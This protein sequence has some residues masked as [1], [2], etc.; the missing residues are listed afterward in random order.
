MATL[1]YTITGSIIVL[2]ILS[3]LTVSWIFKKEHSSLY[4]N[5]ILI[6]KHR[7]VVE[8][9]RTYINLNTW[10]RRNIICP[11]IIKIGGHKTETRC[12]YPPGH[13]EQLSRSLINT[14]IDVKRDGDLLIIRSTPFYK[15]GTRGSYAGILKENFLFNATEIEK[16]PEKYNITWPPKDTRNYRLVWRVWDLEDINLP[17]GNYTNCSYTFG[18]VKI[19]L[20]NECKKL[21]RAEI[22]DDKIY[23]YF[24]PRKNIQFLEIKIVDPPTAPYGYHIAPSNGT[25][26][27]N[28]S[29]KFEVNETAGTGGDLSNITLHIW[30][31]SSSLIYTNT[32]NISGEYNQTNWT[33]TLPS[34]GTYIWSALI[35]DAAGNTNWTYGPDP[36]GYNWTII[37]S[38]LPP[39][40]TNITIFKRGVY[41]TNITELDDINCS[42][43]V[44]DDHDANLLC[45]VTWY[46]DGIRESNFDTTV[47]CTS[48]SICYTDT[49]VTSNYTAVGEFWEV[50]ITCTDSGGLKKER[51]NN[52]TI[53]R[54][55]PYPYC[56]WWPNCVCY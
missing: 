44:T 38:S 34:D 31:S 41:P 42:W 33:Y 25:I 22:K 2:L 6:A 11:R 35:S 14:K 49:L 23:F 3:G 16:F 56:R 27:T 40:I 15:Y 47:N 12:Y 7:W 36:P 18:K 26:T 54:H 4:R 50:N 5:N 28:L 10:Y 46:R 24:K 53:Y 55:C 9:E 20:L 1:K 37:I 13:Y 17:N 39:N 19:D 29:I 8:A 52:V 51:W 48:G 30:N 21:D 43:N 32:T 45:N